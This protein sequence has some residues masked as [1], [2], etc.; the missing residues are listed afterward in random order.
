VGPRDLRWS[1]GS[2]FPSFGRP[3][4]LHFWFGGLAVRRL[5]L[6]NTKQ[7]TKTC[8]LRDNGSDAHHS[9]WCYKITYLPPRTGVGDSG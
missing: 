4:L 9:Y 7:S 6:N 2:T 3:L 8:M 5:V 1:I